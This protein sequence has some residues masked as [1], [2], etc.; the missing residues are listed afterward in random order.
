[1]FTVLE[2]PFLR[3]WTSGVVLLVLVLLLQGIDHCKDFSIL[4]FF[5]FFLVVS[6]YNVTRTLTH[7]CKDGV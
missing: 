3:C 1:M 6:I 5:F 4:Y 7:C 2:A